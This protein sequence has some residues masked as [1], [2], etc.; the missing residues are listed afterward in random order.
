M[1]TSLGPAEILVIL[2]VALIVLGP[3]RLPKAARQLGKAFGEV[4]R[5]SSGV[6]DDLRGALD[7][8]DDDEPARPVAA[9]PDLP[10]ESDDSALAETP[11]PPRVVPSWVVPSPAAEAPSPPP[12]V[13]PSWVVPLSGKRTPPAESPQP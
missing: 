9:V 8:G 12:R 10:R 7:F 5:W 4:R 6:Q 2:I 13:V 3:E 11:V 1:P